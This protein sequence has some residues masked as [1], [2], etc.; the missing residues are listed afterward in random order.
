LLATGFKLFVNFVR[1]KPEQRV[2]DEL[3]ALGEL[4]KEIV[5]QIFP[6]ALL[7]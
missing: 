3:A 7:K 1:L 4:A 6:Y 5:H 2:P